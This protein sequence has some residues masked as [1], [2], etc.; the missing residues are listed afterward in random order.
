MRRGE[1]RKAHFEMVD[2]TKKVDS[3]LAGKPT[4]PRHFSL[5]PFH[6]LIP[7]TASTYLVKGLIPRNG[8]VAV[9]GPPKCGKSFW[10]FDLALHSALGWDYRSRRVIRG[11]TVY[12]AFEG[13]EGYKARAAAFRQAHNIAADL[14]LPFYLVPVRIDLV[15]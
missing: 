9:W 13:A 6:Q 14:V 7:G 12:C 4:E 11:A 15:K 5:V 3:A 2:I 1:R 8:I 10:A